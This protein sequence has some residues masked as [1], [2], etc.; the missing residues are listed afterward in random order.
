MFRG[1]VRLVLLITLSAAATAELPPLVIG[2]LMSR[3]TPPYMWLDRCTGEPTGA[4]V[5]VLRKVLDDLNIP[6]TFAPAMTMSW[7]ALSERRERLRAGQYDALI[8]LRKDDNISGMLLSETPM[9]RL[10]DAILF[11]SDRGL[12]IK[13]ERDLRGLTGAIASS[14]YNVD[15]SLIGRWMAANSLAY[16][17]MDSRED[18]IRAVIAGEVDYIILERYRAIATFL[19][20]P[21]QAWLELVPINTNIRDLHLAMSVNSAYVERMPQISAALSRV[22]ESGRGEILRYTYLR[23][24]LNR[25]PCPSGLAIPD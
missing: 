4:S 16:K 18:I 8:A 2:G 17:V 15:N 19:D 25:D 9:V 11:R 12:Q 13:T 23:T 10:Q 6:Y 21:S 14:E 24:W 20:K 1:A 3:P 7:D 22:E 5:H